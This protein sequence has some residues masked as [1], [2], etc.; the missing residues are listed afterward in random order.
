MPLFGEQGYAATTIAQIE[1]ATGLSPGSGSLSRLLVR[2]LAR[3]PELLDEMARRSSPVTAESSA[4]SRRPGR[5]PPGHRFLDGRLVM[6]TPQVL[7]QG[8]PGDHD[9]GAVILLEPRIGSSLDL[10]WPWSAS[11]GQP[12]PLG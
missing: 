11:I 2:D 6:T 1:A 8:M 9:L 4:A 10:R 5:P 3:F 12:R 7:Y